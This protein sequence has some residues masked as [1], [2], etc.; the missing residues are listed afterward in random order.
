MRAVVTVGEEATDA[1]V[2]VTE[3]LGTREVA[4]EEELGPEVGAVRELLEKVGAG[5]GFAELL[6]PFD[7]L[8]VATDEVHALEPGVGVMSVAFAGKVI[9]KETSTESVRVR[10]AA[11][12]V[13][14]TGTVSSMTL[15]VGRT[16]P[17][18]PAATLE[19]DID[20]VV[21]IYGATDPEVLELTAPEAL[22]RPAEVKIMELAL[23]TVPSGILEETALTVVLG[24]G[25]MAEGE[26]VLGIDPTEA[27]ELAKGETVLEI[28]PTEVPELGNSAVSALEVALGA[29]VDTPVIKPIEDD[30]PVVDFHALTVVL[31]NGSIA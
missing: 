29:V 22:V 21:L 24:K 6:V 3:G 20:V 31:A 16:P 8:V 19:T 13:T 28:N 4:S 14:T 23:L 12:M 27:P 18:L 9:G 11:V 17:P 7:M 5:Y 10:S 1:V 25:T 2:P 15:T 26:T 30:E